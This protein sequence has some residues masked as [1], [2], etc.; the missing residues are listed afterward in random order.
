MFWVKMK[1]EHKH[2]AEQQ[3]LHIGTQKTAIVMPSLQPDKNTGSYTPTKH[4]VD[5]KGED[6]R[7]GKQGSQP[8]K[9]G[10]PEKMSLRKR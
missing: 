8:I 6:M 4:A 3:P 9:K 7:N 1:G 10:P 5:M 2:Q